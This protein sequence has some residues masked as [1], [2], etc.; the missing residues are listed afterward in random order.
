MKV[1]PRGSF[2]RLALAAATSD[3]AL[4]SGPCEHW[5]VQHNTTTLLRKEFHHVGNLL[6]MSVIRGGLDLGALHHGSMTISP[7]VLMEWI[8]RFLTCHMMYRLYWKR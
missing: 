5:T 4:F 8:L 2:F 6:S 7:W 3:P 1:D